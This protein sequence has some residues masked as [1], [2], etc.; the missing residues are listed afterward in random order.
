MK[1]SSNS[2]KFI[3][4]T[5]IFILPLFASA[6]DRLESKTQI[7]ILG[8]F[9]IPA[10]YTT[11]ERY[12]EMKNAGFNL[13]ISHFKTN[14]ENELALNAAQKADI[15]IVIASNEL[16]NETEE[17]V[18]KFMSHPA[19][20]GY[21]LTDEPNAKAFDELGT[22]AKKINA[23]DP[24]HFCYVNLFPNYADTVLLGTKDYRTYV[25][26]FT[27]KVP[28]HFYSFDS[29]PLTNYPGI[30][31]NWH[32]NLEIFAD[33]AKKANK[34]FWGFAQSTHFDDTHEDI[35]LSTLRVQMFTNLAYG[36][37]GLQYF[38]YWTPP[39]NTTESFHGGPIGLDKKRSSVY[40]MLKQ[41]NQEITNLSGVFVG[42]K[43][44][45]VKQTGKNIPKGTIRLSE[46]PA[47]LKV[48]E[49]SG[50]GAIV[51]VLENGKNR[52]I[53]IV[54]RDFKKS[55]NLIL[56]GD[57]NLMKVLKDGSIVPTNTYSSATEIEP[58][59]MAVYKYTIVNK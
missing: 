47:P 25:S 39:A 52:F 8:W 17:T 54:N 5:A 27:N 29:Y 51:S 1:S 14:Y 44:I 7:P 13:S 46:P 30:Y 12:K 41:L 53:V 43:V 32:Q 16:I 36:A 55:M 59:D 49:T 21:F 22:L 11:V 6:Q 4:L 40:D 58:G 34:P 56:L 10:N 19:L 57:D 15:K 42:S 23:I 3:A 26:N 50:E 31:K 33:E 45:S 28:L 38:T 37:Q 9:S 35:S 18:R 2:L 24:T 48:L 20:A